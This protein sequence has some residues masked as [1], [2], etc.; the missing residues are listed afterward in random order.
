MLQAGQR[1]QRC[2]PGQETHVNMPNILLNL[3]L[4]PGPELNSRNQQGAHRPLKRAESKRQHAG[5]I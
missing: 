3:F 2:I 4:E 1:A 5:F